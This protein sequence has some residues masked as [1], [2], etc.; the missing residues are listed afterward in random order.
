MCTRNN[1]NEFFDAA[2]KND[3]YLINKYLEKYFDAVEERD[4]IESGY[5]KGFTALMYAALYDNL[6]VAEILVTSQYEVRT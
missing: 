2:I 6:K 1:K 5:F 3:D 4:D